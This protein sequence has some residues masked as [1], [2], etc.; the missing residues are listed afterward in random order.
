MRIGFEK[1][2]NFLYNSFFII[3]QKL[4]LG[5]FLKSEPHLG[6]IRSGTQIHPQ[7]PTKTHQKNT[8]FLF[9]GFIR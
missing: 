1:C 3:T 9:M 7:N 2:Q 8:K 5:R 6:R 4:F